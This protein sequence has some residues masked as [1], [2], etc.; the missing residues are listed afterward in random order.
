MSRPAGDTD[1]EGMTYPCPICRTPASLDTGCPGCGAPPDPEAAEV[2]ALNAEFDRLRG[3]V[4]SAYEDYRGAIARLEDVR[5]RRNAVAARVAA[6]AAAHTAPPPPPQPPLPAPRP[7]RPARPETSVRTVQNVLFIL[8]GLLLGSAAI[9]FT[10]VAWASFGVVGRAAIL[11]V[12]TVVVLAVPPLALRR[13]LAATAETFAA[14]GLLLVL[15]DGY[16]AWYVNLA[17]LAT[18]LPP[19]AYA[20]AVFAGTAALAWG[21]AAATGLVGPR[22]VALCAAQPV[23]PLLAAR[24]GFGPA[25]WT[26]LCG[27]IALGDLVVA[28]RPWRYGLGIAAGVLAGLAGLTGTVL[29][30]AG[31]ISSGTVAAAL[32]TGTALVL[33]AAVPLAHRITFR[34]GTAALAAATVGAFGRVVLAGWPSW[35]LP[36]L[37]AAVA[38]LALA[39]RVLPRALRAGPRAALGAW[40]GVLALVAAGWSV[41]A[42]V[43]T[44]AVAFP[45]WHADLVPTASGTHARLPLTLLL[46]AVAAG[47]LLP[48]RLIGIGAVT[49]VLLALAVPLPWWGPSVVDGAVAAALLVVAVLV[50]RAEWWCG[51]AGGFLTLHAVG[52][53]LAR[54]Y[55]TAAVT[56]A[57]VLVAA[58]VAVLGRR[59][60]RGVGAVAAGAG[61]LILPLATAAAAESLA[62]SVESLGAAVAGLVVATA[63]LRLLWPDY[64]KVAAVA[65]PL[66]GLGITVAALVSFGPTTGPYLATVALCDLVAVGWWTAA[67]AA[68][69]AVVIVLPAVWLVLVAPHGTV[70]HGVFGLGPAA[71]TLA[72]LSFG[73][74]RAMPVPAG[75]AVLVGAAALGAPWP[76]VP[77]LSLAL[78]LAGALVFALRRGTAAA[79]VLAALTV[80]AGL[81][82]ALETRGTT[83]AALGA[84]TVVA[85]VCAI[86]G[87]HTAIRAGAWVAAVAS[88]AWLAMTAALTADLTVRAAAFW[89]LVPAAIALA[90]ATRLRRAESVAVEAAAHATAAVAALLTVGSL[91]HTAGVCTL[92]GL[93]IGLSALRQRTRIVAAAGTELLALWL[94]LA[95]RH[96]AVLEAYTLPAAAV[97][98]LAGWFVARHRPEVHSW[99]AYGPALLAAFGPST[100]TLL[101]GTGEPARRLALGAAALAVVLGGAVRRRQAPVVVSGAVLGAVA[102]HETVLL[103]DLVQR[104]ILLGLAGLVLI[105][106]AVTYE[107]RRR[108][109]TRLA[110]AVGRMR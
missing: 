10:A 67:V 34:A 68:L 79:A 18:A 97:A 106:L 31:E 15:L 95:D 57:L 27:L 45:A 109:V 43:R 16:A 56:G 98:L 21:Y 5:L 64:R 99:V 48:A 40:T 42:G 107:R 46:L 47:A 1:P 90:V 86:A 59:G 50:R 30:L 100:A 65:V 28:T 110:A 63:V 22:Y 77:G 9:V 78:G 101:A 36:L 8:G 20:G 93:A 54:P 60:R 7:A 6:R 23:L 69:P 66:A 2:V 12:T 105:G 92:W 83:L 96:V 33:L 88:G 24:A 13:R 44:V 51:I 26:V 70:P 17:G 53:S 58:T 71:V 35:T 52:A 55:D 94:L 14:L 82:G 108:D 61:L 3:Q 25:G 75:L 73:A 11:A 80:P 19:T 37:A 29:A 102:V 103:W 81:A 104:W 76:T 74:R 72:L 85:A 39:V 87:R 4:V 41:L 62:A 91:G 32:R 38:I 84:T 89:M 49:A